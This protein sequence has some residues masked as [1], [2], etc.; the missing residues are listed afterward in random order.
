MRRQLL[1]MRLAALGIASTLCVPIASGKAK[2]TSLSLK[3]SPQISFSPARIVATAELKD[4]DETS[5]EFYCPGLEWDWGDGTTSEASFDCEPFEAGRSEIKKRFV[6]EHTFQ[7][8]GRYRVQLRLKRQKKV[9]LSGS[10]TVQVRPGA[11]DG[12]G[13]G[14]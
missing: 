13:I 7:T 12:M 9:I 2:D 14:D 1:A 5:G 11:R 10:T 8:A 3:A 6:A 4:V